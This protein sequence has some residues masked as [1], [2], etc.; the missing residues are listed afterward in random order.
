M[1]TRRATAA[2][3]MEDKLRATL[4]ELESSKTLCRQ[5]LQERDDSEVEVKVIV[6]KNTSLKME[7]AELHI[8]H[9][10]LLDRHQHL[11]EVLAS[12][13]QCSDTHELALSRIS[14]LEQE[15]SKARSSISL[16]E[17]VRSREQASNTQSLFD[18]LVGCSASS[19]S[20][21][22]VTIDLTGEDVITQCP[23]LTSHNKIKK[24]IKCNKSIKKARL[25]LKKLKS[26]KYNII[27]HHKKQIHLVTQLKTYTS[28]L[29]HFQAKYDKDTELLHREL[30][31]KEKL[32]N[33]IFEKYVSSQEQLSERMVE[34]GELLDLVKC[35]AERY[36]SLT[37]N[38]SCEYA[39]TTACPEPL[40]VPTVP[41]V[42]QPSADSEFHSDRWVI[43]SDKIGAGFGTLLNYHNTHNVTNLCYPHAH[44]NNL[45]SRIKDLKF[46]NNTNIVLFV[47][48]SLDLKRRDIVDGIDTLLGLDLGKI[49]LCALPYADT[50]STEQNNVVHYLN[51]TLHLLSSRHSDKLVF[52]DTNNFISGFQLTQGT[53]YLPRRYK[54]LVASL[55]A[56][57]INPVIGDI[58]QNRLSCSSLL[59]NNNVDCL[60]F[61]CRQ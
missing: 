61:Q 18:E 29:K 9:V 1:M 47:G 60:N 4:K 3:D 7:L 55:L 25:A 32:L 2:R 6:D 37:K 31:S 27:N 21:P 8:E 10:D 23:T 12:F 42:T 59:N 20:H 11:Q 36:E 14:E 26:S 48:N 56:Y 17:S 22:V 30:M 53:M 46:K 40:T 34:A 54:F 57:N 19:V 45:I 24:Y 44:F 50:F 49:I 15:L 5:L 13:G 16:L 28:E 41:L 51:N 33:E 43:V 58:T 52:F 35:N 39:S 38:L